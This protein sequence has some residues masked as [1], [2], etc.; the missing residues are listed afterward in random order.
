MYDETSPNVEL[1][2]HL[3]RVTDIYKPEENIGGYLA[4]GK[5]LKVHHKNGTADIELVRTGDVISSEG[6]NEGRFG[7]RL[8]T[9]FAHFNEDSR[10]SSGSTVPVQEGQL[11]ILAFLDGLKGQP[12]IIG[13]LPNT[14]EN[15][16]NILPNQY[17]LK[18]ETD[19][20]DY[21]ESLKMLTVHPSQ[22]YTKIDGDANVELSHPSC[23]FIAMGG[24]P[25]V[26][27]AH[28]GFSHADLTEND[29]IRGT[30]RAA[31]NAATTI[32]VRFLLSHQSFKGDYGSAKAFTK[33]FID[34][35]GSL[36]VSRDNADEKLSYLELC[37]DGRFLLRRQNDSPSHGQGAD[38]TDFSVGTQGEVQVS[39]VKGSNHTDISVSP[40][41]SL[42]VSKTGGGGTSQLQVSDDNTIT[43]TH[44]S[45]SYIQFASN[46]DILIKA[47]GKIRMN[48]G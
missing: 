21:R 43:V 3:G 46:G 10:T 12:V 25:S 28:K 5:V 7:A 39:Q 31:V 34:Q 48:E 15:T 30:T 8:S 13:M 2:P 6:I 23:T 27:D 32:P 37:K 9:S 26:N 11:V 1:Q 29:P 24:D 36:R 16:N 4:L 22:F 45:G 19:R 14:W 33:M 40:T 20:D 35:L 18:A 41:G 17:P 47:K 42:T 44:Q 38:H